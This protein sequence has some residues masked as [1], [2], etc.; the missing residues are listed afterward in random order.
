M[1]IGVSRQDVFL[2]IDNPSCLKCQTR[3]NG[4][5]ISIGIKDKNNVGFYYTAFNTIKSLKTY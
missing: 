1:Q 5:D 3:K 4:K 2:G